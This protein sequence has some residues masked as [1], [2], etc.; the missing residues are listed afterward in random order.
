[1]AIFLFTVFICAA[2]FLRGK[3][4]K[5]AKPIFIIGGVLLASTFAGLMGAHSIYKSDMAAMAHTDARTHIIAS[6]LKKHHVDAL[7]GSF[8]RVMPAVQG[9]NK[10]APMP[11]S[12]C[13]TPTTAQDS[14]NWKIDLSK[15]SFAYIISFDKG[16]VP[17]PNCT[18]DQVVAQYG[19]P[20][21]KFLVA[22]SNDKPLEMLLFYDKGINKNPPETA[23]AVTQSAKSVLSDSLDGVVDAKCPD[24]Q[25]IMN[26][27]AHEDDDL[28]FQSPDLL[29]DI[30]AGHCIR[31]VYV[32][33]GDAGIGQAHWA[34]RER[35]VEVAYA[36]MLGA[37][38]NWT[39]RTIKLSDNEYITLAQLPNDRRAMLAFMHLPDGNIYGTGFSATN[40]ESLARLELNEI[41]IIHSVDGGSSYTSD[42][43]AGAILSMMKAFAPTEIRT[44][45]T[46]SPGKRF[47]DHSDHMA[48]GRY[49]DK[50]TA[51][52]KHYIG[53]PIRGMAPNV[54]ASSVD[55]KAAIFAA[56]SS[57]ANDTGC[58]VAEECLALSTYGSYLRRQYLAP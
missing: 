7:L 42:D 48:V 41:Q 20:S 21:T 49:T 26:I 22:S 5:E 45:A 47:V 27:V 25:T 40:F 37:Q 13:F 17:F 4:F 11:L 54:D 53:Y 38:D 46:Y 43:L 31:S 3:E 10:I 15:H 33:A 56:Y 44:Q 9:N 1:L 32:T 16:L 12:D 23:A 8:W 34:S 18:M 55:Q 2:T 30:G 28:L 39:S 24:N 14:A 58:V 6:E 52:I 35:G 29:N 19:S 50:A 57:Q 36:Q 51:P